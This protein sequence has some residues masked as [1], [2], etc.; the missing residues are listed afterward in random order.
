MTKKE[1]EERVNFL[2]KKL[3]SLQSAVMTNQKSVLRVQKI[4][5]IL[6]SEVRGEKHN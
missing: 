6:L 4:T 2:A 1:L 3:S 5:L